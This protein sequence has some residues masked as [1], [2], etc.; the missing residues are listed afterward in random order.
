M[1]GI[2]KFVVGVLFLLMAGIS[3]AVD[4]LILKP[5]SAPK[6]YTIAAEEFQKFY[7]GGDRQRACN[8]CKS[9]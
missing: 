9:G 5:A 2:R 8:C 4:W 6:A 3:L 1:I 7:Q